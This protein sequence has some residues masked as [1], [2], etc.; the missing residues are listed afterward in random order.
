[1]PQPPDPDPGPEQQVEQIPWDPPAPAAMPQLRAAM[2]RQMRSPWEIRQT[3]GALAMG[4][5]SIV[6]DAPTPEAA[7]QI[8]C[9]Q[10]HQRLRAAE[11]Y[12]VTA[13]MTTL[14]VA[15]GESLPDF[16]LEPPDVP[17]PTGFI[18]FAEPIGSYINTDGG[19][20]ARVPIVAVNWGPYNLP[21]FPRGGIWFTYYT[22]T[23]FTGLERML[24][25]QASRP[26]KPAERTR[27]RQI[28]DPLTWDN[29]AALGYGSQT[30]AHYKPGDSHAGDRSSFAPWS[31]TLR[32]AWLLMNQPNI[33][34][35]EDLHRSRASTRRDQRDGLSTGPVR[36]L[37]LRPATRAQGAPDDDQAARQYTCRWMV[38]GHWRQQWYPSRQVHR[39]IWI[40]PHI[41]GPDGRPLKAS[42]TVHIWDR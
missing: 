13:D 39:P 22:P 33:A 11:L 20:H 10:E 18:V 16:H 35:A 9:E 8:L 32:A 28:R 42:E 31:Q 2:V 37:R 5:G 24:A 15:A 29:E 41:K 34:E 27:L 6:P 30:K 19:Y 3:A 7:A 25:A 14:A 4:R 38:K 40:N 23:D 12:F 17:S 21:A 1:M 26:A 36:L